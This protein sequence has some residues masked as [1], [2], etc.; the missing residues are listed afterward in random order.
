MGFAEIQCGA[1]MLV[2]C[3]CSL[4]KVRCTFFILC[5]ALEINMLLEV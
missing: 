2:L 4:T 1:E 5:H 3:Q